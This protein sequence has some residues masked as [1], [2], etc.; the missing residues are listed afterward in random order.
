MN[1][2]DRPT[3]EGNRNS[4]DEP[5]VVRLPR[6]WLGPREELIPFGPRADEAQSASAPEAGAPT[7]ADFWSGEAPLAAH[8][9]I[10]P[11][12]ARERGGHHLGRQSRRGLWSR[13]REWTMGGAVSVRRATTSPVPRVDRR[14]LVGGGVTA[15]ILAAVLALVGGGSH[16]TTGLEAAR[17]VGRHAEPRSQFM[18]GNL[19]RLGG[20]LSR[21]MRARTAERSGQTRHAH[22]SGRSSHR[23]RG[24]PHRIV[25][26][27]QPVTYRTPPSGSSSAGNG[28]GTADTSSG[29]SS[30]GSANG[31]SS[32]SSP[33]SSSSNPTATTTGGHSS[34]SQPALGA[35]G[36]L[37][38]GSSP[39]G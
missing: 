31:A 37:A 14:V 4:E 26:V 12:D 22:Q 10:D 18:P 23:S 30:S 34:G 27:S 29:T 16:T 1:E 6:D 17:P 11:A 25:V 28:G 19:T 20:H 13:R 39:D 5:N 36:S 3:T 24:G 9:A 33:S 15:V 8:G 2:E 35:S 32:G 7:A 38:P 21:A